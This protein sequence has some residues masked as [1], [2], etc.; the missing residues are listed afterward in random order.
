[1][2]VGTLDAEHKPYLTNKGKLA[3]LG[4]AQKAQREEATPS[5]LQEAQRGNG[6]GLGV[7]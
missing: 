7:A 3:F 4:G 6:S 2:S 1:M 5:P